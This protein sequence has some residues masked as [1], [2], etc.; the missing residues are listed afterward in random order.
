MKAV[1]CHEYGPPESLSIGELPTPTPSAD[2]ALIE[3]YASGVNLD[4]RFVRARC[5]G[6]EF[7]DAQAFRR[8]IL[9]TEHCFHGGRNPSWD[10]G[11]ERAMAATG[12]TPLR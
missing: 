1:L 7:A 6:W 12:P 8:T 2:E 3:I 9:M 10:A 4:E 11:L 5:W